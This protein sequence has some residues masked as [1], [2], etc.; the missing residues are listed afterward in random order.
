M[1]MSDLIAFLTARL[2]ED[3][4]TALACLDINERVKVRRGLTPPRWLTSPDSSD[5]TDAA[6]ILRVRHT[7]VREGE[8]IAR[9]DPARTLR[10][11]EADR[12]LLTA[13]DE[14]SR[15]DTDE[16]EPEFAH[17]RAVGLGEA[18]RMRAERFSDHPEYRTEWSP[19]T[20]RQP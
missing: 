20:V 19:R 8:H 6:G 3:A 5:I 18:V 11:V 14:V 7:W 16:P 17:G 9:H 15:Y 2:D 13:Y 1:A 10:E 4:A 12:K